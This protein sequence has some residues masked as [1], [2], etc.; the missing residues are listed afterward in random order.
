MWGFIGQICNHI[1]YRFVVNIK[2][3]SQ[4]KMANI[5]QFMQSHYLQCTNLINE[6]LTFIVGQQY[7]HG[8]LGFTGR[9]RPHSRDVILRAV[10]GATGERTMD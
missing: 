7:D 10:G 6:C 2:R 9:A 4:V 8:F 3:S 5:W 1:I